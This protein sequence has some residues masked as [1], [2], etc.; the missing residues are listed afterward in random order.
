MVDYIKVWLKDI[1]IME[2]LNNSLSDFRTDVSISTGSIESNKLISYYKNLKI[3]I[4]AEKYVYLEGSL[5]KYYK[6]NNGGAFTFN[7]LEKILTELSKLFSFDLGLAQIRNFE[8]GVN[9]QPS[10]HSMEILNSVVAYK[11]EIMKF[12]NVMLRYDATRYAFK[13]YSKSEQMLKDGKIPNGD[14][15]RLEYKVK[16]MIQVQSNKIKNLSDLTNQQKMKS[17]EKHLL[18]AFD[19]I[20]FSDFATI[21]KI[22][23][24]WEKV[25][26]LEGS[27]PKYLQYYKGISTPSQYYRKV[28]KYKKLLHKKSNNCFLE[29]RN[30]VKDQFHYLANN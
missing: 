14:T 11:N 16:R 22:G 3:T 2:L 7:E 23:N 30:Q 21:D 9:I 24:P 17:L 18:S 29:L 10:I 26:L 1:S 27:N 15:L 25:T 13:I 5:H 6:G 12:D 19:N 4:V 28:D 20:L 8:F